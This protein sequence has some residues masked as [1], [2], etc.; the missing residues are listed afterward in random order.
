MKTKDM[1]AVV[2]PALCVAA[3]SAA[4]AAPFSASAFLCGGSPA[5]KDLVT[6]KKGQVFDLTDVTIANGSGAARLV[7]VIQGTWPPQGAVQSQVT[8]QVPPGSTFAQQFKT[9][10]AYRGGSPDKA[11]MVCSGDN[12]AVYVTVSGDLR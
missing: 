9:P 5:E 10:I 6:L 1:L 4:H 7:G 3:L 8:A 12:L 11:K 2:A